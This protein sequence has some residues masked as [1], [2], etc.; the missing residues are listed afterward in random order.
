MKDA[1]DRIWDL[2]LPYQDQRDD[3]GHAEITLHYAKTL[4]ESENGNPDVV[5]P[6]IILHDVGY[7][8]L[9]KER[10]LKVFDRDLKDEERR[11]VQREHE[12]AGVE[13]ARQILEGMSYP[14][15]LTGEIL[16][17]ISQHDTRKGFISRNEGLVRDADKLWRFS[18]RGFDTGLKR[19]PGE[20]PRM[21]ERLQSDLEKPDYIYSETARRMAREELDARRAERYIDQPLRFFMDRLASKSPE[22]GGGS[23]AA[24]VGALGAALV[25]MVANL[26]LEKEKYVAVQA[27]IK[28]LLEESETLRTDMQDLMQ[29][30]TEAYR[31]LSEVYRMNRDTEGERAGRNARL[32]DALKKA[33]EVPLEI[34]AKSLGVARLAQRA[35]EIGNVAAV[36]DAGVAVLLARACA[37]AAALNV[38]INLNKIKDVGYSRETWARMQDVLVGVSNLEAAVIE[39]TYKKLATGMA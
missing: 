31:A 39:L 28:A 18:R 26:T 32:Q 27:Q 10:R 2:A 8:Q 35:A 36:S 13:L 6:A 37:E 11:V 3:P 15:D 21:I 30:D 33:C 22:P 7:S 34:G 4:V 5:L 17:V 24:L 25:S 16:E 38:K 20:A 29:K 1:F 12:E 9:T 19:R 14:A 23:V